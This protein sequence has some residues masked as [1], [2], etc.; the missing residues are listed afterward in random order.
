MYHQQDG[1]KHHEKFFLGIN[2]LS[3]KDPIFFTREPPSN[4]AV[5]TAV[6]VVGKG[7]AAGGCIIEALLDLKFTHPHILT[8]QPLSSR[9]LAL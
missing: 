8:L 9:M 3:S 4:L 6:A 5:V 1:E 2:R 7:Y